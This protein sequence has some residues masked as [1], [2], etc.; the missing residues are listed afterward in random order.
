MTKI[1]QKLDIQKKT[2]EKIEEYV[3]LAL[4]ELCKILAGTKEGREEFVKLANELSKRTK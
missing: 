1:Y 3:Q 2:E 4:A